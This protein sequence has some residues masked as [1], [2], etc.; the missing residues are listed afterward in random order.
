MTRDV[1]N[2]ISRVNT[3]LISRPKQRM[4]DAQN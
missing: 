2:N 1:L 3:V 4:S